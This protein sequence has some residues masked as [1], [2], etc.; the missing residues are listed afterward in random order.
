MKPTVPTKQATVSLIKVK[1]RNVLLRMLQLCIGRY[2]ISVLRYK[3]LILDSSHSHAD[4][5]GRAVEGAGLRPLACWDCEF[6][7]RQR[8]GILSVVIVVC[9]QVEVSASG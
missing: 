8:H 5:S 3:V 6:E 7:S 9:C 2:L 4:T 1:S